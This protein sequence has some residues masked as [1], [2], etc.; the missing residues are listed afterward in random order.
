VADFDTLARDLR[1]WARAKDARDLAAAELLIWHEFWL[2]RR[3]FATAAIVKHGDVTVI[4]WSA[5]R[6]F[7]DSSPRGST[8]ELAVLDLAAAI[9]EDRY[10]LSNM[11]SAHAR[12]IVTAFATALGAALPAEGEGGTDG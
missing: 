3:D 7:L 11:G 5:V 12:A 10:K 2:R 4:R 6:E 1:C 9:G 8:S